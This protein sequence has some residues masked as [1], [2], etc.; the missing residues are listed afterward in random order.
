MHIIYTRI[1]MQASKQVMFNHS[2]INFVDKFENLF[3]FSYNPRMFDFSFFFNFCFFIFFLLVY[4]VCTD[5][6]F[7]MRSLFTIFVW[8]L[9][10]QA[11]VSVY[12]VDYSDWR[13]YN[14]NLY[15]SI[16]FDHIDTD[17]LMQHS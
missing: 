10:F 14:G 15:H 1:R 2:S 6:F 16:F 8:Y 7:T 3:F 5:F 4:S 17:F 11:S 12:K 9:I 13:I